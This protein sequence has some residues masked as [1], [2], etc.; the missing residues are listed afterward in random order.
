[1]AEHLVAGLSQEDSFRGFAVLQTAGGEEAE[2][3]DIDA[4]CE[5]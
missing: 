5:P 3:S 1:M 2:G 4:R